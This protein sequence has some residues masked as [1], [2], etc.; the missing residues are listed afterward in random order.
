MRAAL[1]KAT[2]TNMTSL[3][4][5]TQD[6]RVTSFICFVLIYSISSP[7]LRRS[8]RVTR[9]IINS[10]D[11]NQDLYIFFCSSFI[12]IMD[13]SESP[14]EDTRAHLGSF[15]KL[16]VAVRLLIWKALFATIQST[17][18]SQSLPSPNPLSILS[19]SRYLSEEIS[20]HLYRGTFR[21]C[22]RINS[23][24]FQGYYMTAKVFSKWVNRTWV[25]K[26]STAMRAYLLNFPHA[27]T[28]TGTLD[29][30]IRHGPSRDLG[31]II[32]LWLKVNDLADTILADQRGNFKLRV[33][34]LGDW[35]P[36]GRRQGFTWAS[37]NTTY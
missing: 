29:I 10:F 25:L 13:S 5:W 7:F 22:I 12:Q 34:L 32:N 17:L 19:C 8:L 23:Q 37:T 36:Q 35:L 21:H 14:K 3:G 18:E 26:D 30:A 9:Q 11:K 4:S 16:P 33:V 6:I 28:E 2:E 24:Y 1:E 15:F 27:K 20:S 31:R